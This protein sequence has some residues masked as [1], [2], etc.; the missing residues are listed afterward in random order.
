MQSFSETLALDPARAST[1]LYFNWYDHASAGM[2]QDDIHVVNPG[3][4]DSAGAIS[5]PG[6]A[7][8]AFSVPAGQERYYSWPAGGIGGPVTVTVSSGPGVLA[9][10]R[11]SMPPNFLEWPA[12]SAA[13]ATAD[14]WFNWYDFASP[15]MSDD[16]HV[17]NPGPSDSTVSLSLP[18]LADVTL[19][20]PSGQD[21]WYTYPKGTIGGPLRVRVL[22]GSPVLPVQ[23]A[24]LRPPPPRPTFRTLV[25]PYYHQ[26]YELSCE[27]AALR[28]ALGS[29]GIGVSEDQILSNIGI[30]WR[31]AYWDASGAFHWGDPYASYVGDPNGS[32]VAL[33][34]YGTYW[35]TIRAAAASFGGS[36]VDAGEGIPPSAVY[37]HIL[38]GHP[39]VAWVSFDWRYHT[40]SHY[41]AFDGRWVQFGAP[42][43][44]AVTLVGVNADSVLV[45][46]PWSGPQWVSKSTFESAYAS[47]NDMSVTLQ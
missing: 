4:Q 9:S 37:D 35:S 13:D 40:V 2:Q 3:S 30:D 42:W 39:V 22:S 24:F 34:G 19:T 15:Y 47:L 29:E 41:S 14:A 5:A 27:E 10:Q 32:E 12:L 31:R 23:R 28:M 45:N 43:E 1:T 46:N 7:P 8:I 38:D 21:R 44:H 16:V 33:T 6:L 17:A 26:S 11:L 18:G 25:V 36:V 20:V